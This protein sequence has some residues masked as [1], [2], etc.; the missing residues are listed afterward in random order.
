MRVLTKDRAPDRIQVNLNKSINDVKLPGGRGI[1]GFGQDNNYPELIENLISSSVTGVSVFRILSKFLTGEGLENNSLNEIKV[2]RD[3]NGNKITVRKFISQV[4]DQIAKFNGVYIHV[5]R[6]LE[7][8][9]TR[10][11]VIN[12]PKCRLSKQDDLGYS[13]KVVTSTDWS[14]YK[15]SVNNVYELYQ[16]LN[17]DWTK[18]VEDITKHKGQLY[19]MFLN[20]T[21][22]YPLSTFDSVALDLATENEISEF[23]YN[24]AAN[25]FTVKTIIVV[26]EPETTEA[27]EEIKDRIESMTGG[28][29]ERVL[30]MTGDVDENGDVKEKGGI[31]IK[32]VKSSIDDKTFETWDSLMSNRIRKAAYALPAVLIDYEESK[33]GSTSGEGIT[34]AVNF[35]NSQTTDLRSEISDILKTLLGNF[36]NED[37]RNN[38][39]WAIRK[40]VL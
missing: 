32:E 6:N 7:G 11:K 15:K 39:N 28:E 29:G 25:G 31:V 17:S 20:N 9:V 13:S 23:R 22:N 35:Y 30:V 4:A 18:D 3:L 27:G 14:N 38:D 36:D 37:L 19:Y 21:Y 10:L 2:G 24:E 40:L 34:Q 1:L 16:S 26:P 12:F 8:H 33:L 5:N